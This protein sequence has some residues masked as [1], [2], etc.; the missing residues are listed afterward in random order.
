MTFHFHLL[1]YYT[2]CLSAMFRKETRLHR[3]AIYSQRS[4]LRHY[5]P[6]RKVAGSIPVEVNDFFQFT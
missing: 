3:T 4:W 1:F 6:S 5:A 2:V